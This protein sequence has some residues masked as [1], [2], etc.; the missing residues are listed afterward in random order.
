MKQILLTLSFIAIYFV[1]SSYA[2]QFYVNRESSS[3]ICRVQRPDERP[4]Y[5]DHYLGAFSTKEKAIS[6]MCKNLDTADTSKCQQVVP[7]N[8]C[9][10]ISKK[11]V[12]AE[13]TS[14]AKKSKKEEATVAAPVAAPAAK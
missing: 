4:Q 9:G 5:G 1:S 10:A 6:E 3:G 7:N 12:H 2:E 11:R 13:K 8:A 14:K